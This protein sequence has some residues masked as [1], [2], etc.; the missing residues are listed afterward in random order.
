[1]A[2][3]TDEW[4]VTRRYMAVDTLARVN[5]EN[6]RSCSKERLHEIQISGEPELHHLTGR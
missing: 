3:Q 2:E 5:T 1:M 6:R 4:Q